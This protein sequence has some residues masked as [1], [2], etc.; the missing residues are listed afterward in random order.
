MAELLRAISR[1]ADVQVIAEEAADVMIMLYRLAQQQD[2]DL[3][4]CVDAKMLINRARKWRQCGDGTG[5]KAGTQ[6]VSD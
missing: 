5:Y 3:Q 2:F 1:G 6:H 4:A